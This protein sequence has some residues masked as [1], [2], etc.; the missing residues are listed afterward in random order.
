[1]ALWDGG[2]VRRYSP[3]G[4]NIGEIELPVPRITSCAFGGPGPDRL[5]ITT[6]S[7]GVDPER[8]HGP[9]GALFVADPGC[10]GVE[11][12]VVPAGP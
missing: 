2:K 7:T 1:M 4:Q 5:F 11:E 3:D 12:W 8:S 9:D 10:R 6:A